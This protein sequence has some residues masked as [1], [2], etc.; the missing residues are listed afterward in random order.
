M[1]GN[2]PLFRIKIA[3]LS[4]VISGL[5]ITGL[6]FYSLTVMNRV[7]LSRID[8]EILALGEGHLAVRPP[9]DYWRNFES[10]LQFIYGER[11]ENLIVEVKDEWGSVLFRS[12]RWPGEIT[13]G[14]FPGFDRTMDASPPKPSE[15]DRRGPPP[16][17]YRACEG[18]KVGEAAQ[19]TDARGVLL[20]GTCETDN[21]KMVLRPHANRDG[22][23]GPVQGNAQA[24]DP[25]PSSGPEAKRPVPR[26][27]KDPVF[28]TLRTSTGV[29]RAGIMG[30][31]RVTITAGM[32]MADHYR[33]VERYRRA[34]LAIV[35]AALFLIAAGGW[36]IAWRA[37]RPVSVITRTAEMISV[38]ALEQ[39]VPSVSADSELSR[40]VVV[41]NNMLDRLEK[42]FGQA[43]RF[44]ADAAHELQT[45][46]SVLL[47][48]LD[49]AVQHAPLGSVEQRRYSSLLEEVQRLRSIVQKLLVLAR[50]DAGRLELNV[51]NVDLSALAESAAEDAAVMA[52][53]LRVEKDIVPGV[54]VKADPDLAGQAMQNLVSNAVKY[55]RE[56][57]FIRLRVFPDRDRA[58]FT[59]V[60]SGVPVPE[61][62]AEM[63]FDRFYR[64]DR[65]RSR[66]VPGSGLGLSLAREIARA[67]GG[68]VCLDPPSEGTV[69]FSLSLPLS[70]IPGD[71]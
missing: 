14:S 55:N 29:W 52:P 24:K 68:E 43:V 39:R 57:G 69:S 64:M 2:P 63:I 35:P 62:D 37:L 9:Q 48:E 17:A 6:G 33:D 15:T 19:F 56:G 27:K 22:G 42:S 65:S 3:L 25:G 4:F 20:R 71:A 16:E 18:K 38:R 45:P 7:S 49:D 31:D 54:I 36:L 26:F 67:H 28:A 53:H 12:A 61:D 60:N 8:R 47:G 32:N 70:S 58:R 59:I 11:S 34:F 13:E 1:R 23:N 50:A 40:L 66:S 5:V 46:L 10:S 51:E 44:S 41:I 21:G 30:S